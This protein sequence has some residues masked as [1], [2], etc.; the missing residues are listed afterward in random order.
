MK[1]IDPR[2]EAK[3]KKLYALA[4]QGPGAFFRH[5]KDIG[6]SSCLNSDKYGVML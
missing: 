6:L 1:D 3:L 2:L 5:Q 4:K